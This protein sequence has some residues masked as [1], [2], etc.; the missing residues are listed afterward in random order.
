MAKAT[1]ISLG[2]ARNLLD[3]EII[4]GSLK[5]SGFKIC[6]GEKP[7]DLCV[8]NTCAFINSAREES[9]DSILE[10]VSLK[11]SG[12]IKHLVV[13]GCLPQL[14]KD[15]L[16]RELRD[17]DLVLGT[18]DF[19]R[20][21]DFIK[22]LK[23][24][25]R[26]TAVS[27]RPSYLYDEDSPRLRLTP[28]HYAYVKISEGCSNFCSY[29]IISRL[30]GA[31]RSR[32]IESVVAEVNAL[33]KGGALKEINLIG[34]DTTAFGIDRYGKTVFPALLK[35]LCC[36]KNNVRWVRIL[37]THPGHYTDELIS[38]I[39]GEER[40]C[41]YLDLPIQHISDKI[42]KRMNR[43]TT[44]K[45]IMELIDKL[46]KKIPGVALRTSIITGF[47]GETEENFKELLEFLSRTKI[48]RLGA[49]MYSKEDGTRAAGF[50]SHIPDRIKKERL[51]E[52]MKLQRNISGKLNASL[53]GSAVEVLI[54][55]KVRGEKDRFLGRR[56][57]DAPEVDGVVY[58]TGKGLKA[59]DFQKVRIVDTLEYDLVGRAG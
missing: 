36:L 1:I 9:I 43:R 23:N 7:V 17:I 33:S 26:R 53:L 2:C 18:A 13:C 48:E 4:A 15:K 58:V 28:G 11:R 22:G 38:T 14:Y 57:A 10:A 16:S 32:R 5:R 3:S 27:S 59:G 49:F 46:R 24:G 29:C 6:D 30:R 35:R 52:L 50:K 47:P 40:I 42:L 55:E 8:I 21:A 44:K 31:F 54:D 19:P 56:Y 12:R 41:K 45:G 37:Y 39:R 20:I 51:D 34:Q 25:F